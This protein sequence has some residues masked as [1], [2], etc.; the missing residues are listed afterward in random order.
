MNILLD[1]EQQGEVRLHVRDVAAPMPGA[2]M[3]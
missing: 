2:M 1:G 3:S